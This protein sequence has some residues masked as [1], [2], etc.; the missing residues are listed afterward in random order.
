MSKRISKD[1]IDR[2]H[3][4]GIYVPGRL[5]SLET[6]STDEG[7]EHGVGYSMAQRVIKNL[8]LLDS[9]S[10]API[11]L[12]INTDGGDVCQGMG[13]YAAIRACRSPVRGIVTASACSMGSVILQACDVRVAR[14]YTTIMYHAGSMDGAGGAPFREGLRAVKYEEELG[15]IIDRIM[16]ER[17]REKKPHLS[18]AKF[19]VETDRGI[20]CTPAQALEWG[21]LDEVEQ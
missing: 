19:K 16:Y 18:F 9:T 8:Y 15:E 20:Y 6:P 12:L 3:D 17:V 14:P 5:V 11:T 1:D 10:D 7:D 4:Y 21:F 13:I 2:L